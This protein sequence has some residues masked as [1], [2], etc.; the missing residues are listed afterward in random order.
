MSPLWP[1]PSHSRSAAPVRLWPLPVPLST[2]F[3]LFFDWFCLQGLLPTESFI[4]GGPSVKQPLFC[5]HGGCRGIGFSVGL[6]HGRTSE[7][8]NLILFELSGP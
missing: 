1:S 5:P 7:Q 4:I 2:I 8:V 3:P 6:G